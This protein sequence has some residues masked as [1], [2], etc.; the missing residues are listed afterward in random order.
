VIRI[1]R[2]FLGF[3]LFVD[4]SQHCFTCRPSDS[5]VSDSVGII[6]RTVATVAFT[7][8]RSN[9]S[10]RSPK[11]LLLTSMLPVEVCQS[12][13]EQRDQSLTRTLLYSIPPELTPGAHSTLLHY[14]K[15]YASAQQSKEPILLAGSILV[16]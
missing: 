9:H 14:P 6:P 1:K 12:L 7:A 10:A 16:V 2:D 4:V 15:K 8:R 11:R 3:F 5:T 13:L